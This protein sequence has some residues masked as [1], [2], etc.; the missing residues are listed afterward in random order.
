[1]EGAEGEEFRRIKT[2]DKAEGTTLRILSKTII[3]LNLP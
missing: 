1:M 2:I 3:C